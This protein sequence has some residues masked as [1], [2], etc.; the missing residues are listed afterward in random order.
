[1]GET[2]RL[3]IGCLAGTVIVATIVGGFV[4]GAIIS[5]EAHTKNMQACIDTGGSWMVRTNGYEC[6]RL[7]GIKTP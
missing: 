5:N 2:I 3:L 4:Y 6:L 1:M 7:T